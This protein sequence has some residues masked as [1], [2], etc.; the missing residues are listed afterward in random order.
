[1]AKRN[2]VNLN[3]N[4]CKMCMPMGAALAFK[5]IEN[6]ILLLLA[7]KGAVLISDDT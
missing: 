6:S 3:V 1:M 2:Y 5:G 4:P 7:H